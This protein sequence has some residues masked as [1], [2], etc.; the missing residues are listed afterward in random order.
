ME[1]AESSLD[2]DSLTPVD[3]ASL[4]GIERRHGWINDKKRSRHIA[5]ALRGISALRIVGGDEDAVAGSQP[6]IH[7]LDG[8]TD[9]FHRCPQQPV[10]FGVRLL[11]IAMRQETGIFEIKKMNFRRRT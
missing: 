5:Q 10:C 8:V 4:K 7:R 6:V 11:S 9:R 2:L 3:L 1:V